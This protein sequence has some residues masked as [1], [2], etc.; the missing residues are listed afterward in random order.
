MVGWIQKTS[1]SMLPILTVSAVTRICTA[2]ILS[3]LWVDSFDLKKH[4]RQNVKKM[5]ERE[6]EREIH[7]RSSS[8]IVPEF[9]RDFAGSNFNRLQKLVGKKKSSWTGFPI[10]RW[11]A[12]FLVPPFW[13]DAC[14][15]YTERTRQRNSQSQS[16]TPQLPKKLAHFMCSRGIA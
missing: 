2:N 9:L 14:L 5:R 3:V 15:F 6:R 16:I 10:S 7:E 12:A 1:V 11:C 4:A 8:I 13:W